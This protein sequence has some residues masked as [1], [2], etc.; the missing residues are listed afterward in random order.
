MLL[1]ELNL[2]G[3]SCP[4]PV[5]QVKKGLKDNPEGLIVYVDNIAACENITRFS[6]T[7]GYNVDTEEK[8]KEWI[9]KISK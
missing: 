3:L 1:K 9:L 4:I 5:L 7:T 8:D 6:Q 2:R